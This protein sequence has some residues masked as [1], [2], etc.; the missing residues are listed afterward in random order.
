MPTSLPGRALP[1]RRAL[2]RV[3][4]TVTGRRETGTGGHVSFSIR[5]SGAEVR[6]MAYEP[7]KNFREII[8]ALVPGDTIIAVGSYKKGSINLEKICL[9]VPARDIRT[10]PPL[11]TACNKRMTSAGKDKGYKCRKCG[12]H[13][14]DPEVQESP[15]TSVPGGTKCR[16]PPADISQN[17]C[18]GGYR[19]TPYR[20]G[21]WKNAAFRMVI[22]LRKEEGEGN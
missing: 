12:A 20:E 22:P 21:Y 8:R 5:D 13:E 7:T 19:N 9:V 6:C 14:K 2:Y 1:A 11:C 10:Q 3:R 16:R 4:G 15:R 18:A 17:R